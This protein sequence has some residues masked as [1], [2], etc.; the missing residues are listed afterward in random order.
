VQAAET[1]LPHEAIRL[2]LQMVESAISRKNRSAYIE[3][4]THLKRIKSLYERLGKETAWKTLSGDLRA[5]HRTL[6]AFQ[7][8]LTKAKL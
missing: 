2:Y 4:I 1:T 7:E 8:E 5:K 6:R 3:A